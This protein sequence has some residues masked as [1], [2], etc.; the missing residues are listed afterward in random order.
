LLLLLDRLWRLLLGL[1]LVS[2]RR[3]QELLLRLYVSF[4]I[5]RLLLLLLQE[6]RD[7]VLLLLPMLVVCACIGQDI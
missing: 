4:L 1:L 6:L 2:E 5:L 7:S 3:L